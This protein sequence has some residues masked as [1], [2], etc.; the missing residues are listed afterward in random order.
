MNNKNEI[1]LSL[2][3]LRFLVTAGEAV[4]KLKKR[5]A[6]LETKATP[7]RKRRRPPLK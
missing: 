5:V 1:S 4:I 7:K 6:V 2:D 3:L